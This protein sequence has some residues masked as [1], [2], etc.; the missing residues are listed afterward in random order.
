MSEGQK[1]FHQVLSLAKPSEV[2]AGAWAYHNYN[3]LLQGLANRTNHTLEQACGVFSALS[4][5]N[6][7]LGNLL[8]AR[9]LLE[10]HHQG[11]TIND[12]KVH[13]YGSNKG[14]AWNIACGTPPEEVIT[15]HKT[16][17]FYFNLL[18]PHDP[19]YVTIDGDRGTGYWPYNGAPEFKP[20]SLPEG[21]IFFFAK[22]EGGPTSASRAS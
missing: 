8:D 14:K 2:H 20:L 17:N 15:A 11:K 18:R 10:A 22:K 1:R 12:F 13:T 5:N 6:G 7:Y 4:P 16:R 3:F 9:R 21:S 19:N